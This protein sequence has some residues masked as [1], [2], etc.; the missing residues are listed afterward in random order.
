MPERRRD[1][2]QLM[3]DLAQVV[4]EIRQ[5]AQEKGIDK[6][7]KREINAAVAAARRDLRANGRHS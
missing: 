5:E 3:R 1:P 7:T 6:M 4:A 2:K